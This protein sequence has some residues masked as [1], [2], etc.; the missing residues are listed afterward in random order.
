MW[1]RY[2]DDTF[3]LWPYQEDVQT[4][5]E[6]VNSIRPS[7]QFTMEK[8]QINKLP[9]LD[10]LVTRTEQGFRSFLY[11]KPTFTGQY[12]N[13]NCYHPYN[14]KKRIVRRSQHRAKAISSD[15]GTYQ[16]EMIS[17]RHNLHR[18]NN[19]ERITSAA[20]NL[21]GRIED[22]TRKLTTLC[23]TLCQKPSRKNLNDFHMTSG[24]YSQVAQLS[25]GI[26]SVSSYQQNSTW[27]RIVRTP[28]LVIVVKYTKVRHAT[29]YKYVL[30]NIEKKLFEVKL[31]IWVL[32]AI[33]ETKGETIYPYEMKLI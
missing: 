17:L 24:Q 27:R 7:L 3:I 2:V 5:L 18:N 31:K 32:R 30:R 23:L 10:V 11:R 9:F 8:E 1:L 13:F 16:E 28:S 6:D 15:M 22:N 12:L 14:V 33:Y 21:N 26:S 29:H 20:R 19:P 25:G 4:L